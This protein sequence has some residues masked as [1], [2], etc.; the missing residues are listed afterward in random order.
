MQN[1]V[2]SASYDDS[3]RRLA[4]LQGGDPA[5]FVL[6]VHSFIEGVLRASCNCDDPMDDS[7]PA[8]LGEFKSRLLSKAT[9]YIP[10]LD[11]LGLIRQQHFLTNDVRHRFAA[12]T[13]EDARTATQHLRRFCQLAG[14][15]EGEGLAT[16]IEYLKAWDDRRSYAELI[17]DMND[18]GYRYQIEKKSAK[19]MA[20]R[21]SELEA[22]QIEM[23][24]L[25]E[26]IRAKD[27]TLAELE[28]AK[29]K[30]D[31]RVDELRAERAAL[32]LELKQAKV[33]AAAFDDAQAYIDA[34]SRM[35]VLT[36][37][38]ADYEKSVTR[39]T[40]EQK[41]V[42]D[43]IQFNADF[44]VKGAAG[45]G[46]T[47]VL[48][49]A[50]ERSRGGGGEQA[51]LDLPEIHG[52]AAVLTYTTTLVK[53]DQYLSS[54]MASGA[55]EGRVA[56]ADSFLRERLRELDPS[57]AIEYRLPEELAKR[58]PAAGLS[59][60]ELATEIELFIWGNDVSYGEY[61]VQGIERRGMKRPLSKEQRIAVWTAAEA[62]EAAMTSNKVYTR[63][64]A[65]LLLAK[66]VAG[67][68]AFAVTRTDYVFIDEAQDLP[69]AVLKAIKSCTNRCVIL[70]GD[71]DQSIYQPGFSFK[72]AGIDISG[73]ARILRTNF[74]NTVELHE[75][76]ER[77]R[78]TGGGSDV[79]NEPFAFRNGPRPELYKAADAE[80]MFGLL[81]KRL[82]LFLD[83]LGYSP[84]NICIIVPRDDDLQGLNARLSAEGLS[85]VD[86]REKGFD[87]V[88]TGS[89]RLTTM[90]S[91][92]GL[93]FPVVL[94]YIPSF[95]VINSSMDPAT[96]DRMARN[97]IYVAMTRAMD[98]LNVFI[99][100]ETENAALLDL[101]ACFAPI[102]SEAVSEGSQ[103]SV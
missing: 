100:E 3:F 79:E 64:R 55:S 78:R 50:I 94:L 99:R 97:L 42:L 39:L 30:K 48:L 81:E 49:K 22:A 14:I 65:A 96:S 59:A 73:R 77:Y 54:L 61:V 90:H 21:V 75:I 89:V 52:T 70:A 80:E 9:G 58:F 85:L 10:H 35:T 20:E 72:R 16:L 56:T 24:H 57:L 40:P 103:E 71:A 43:Q 86:I 8:F 82:F 68:I 5:F 84:E 74:R 62:M 6:A 53:Y 76:T 88:E 45:T 26:Q 27:Q 101:A 23:A 87:F 36:R 13:V 31:A 98:H 63:N 93:D 67:N 1:P 83:T 46:K 37:T 44:L 95:H 29:E 69:A 47:L 66:A 7:F 102:I 4:K 2:P 51:H 25:K 15:P 18:L 92:K 11:V 41:K 60:R 12:A 28:A 32:A 34:I 17:R 38:R 19:E 91:A 33:K